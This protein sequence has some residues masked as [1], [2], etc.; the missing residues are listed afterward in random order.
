[1]AGWDFPTLLNQQ[2]LRGRL[3]VSIVR[4]LVKGGRHG[5]QSR[6][7]VGRERWRQVSAELGRRLLDVH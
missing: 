6:S 2:A 5:R 3:F 1:M 7:R 4:R